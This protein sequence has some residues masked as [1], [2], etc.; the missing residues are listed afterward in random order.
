[1]FSVH[2]YASK[3]QQRQVAD[4]ANKNMKKALKTI[5]NMAYT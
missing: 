2:I 1:M 5:V 4:N 3:Q